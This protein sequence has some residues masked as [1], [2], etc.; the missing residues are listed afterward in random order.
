MINLIHWSEIFTKFLKTHVTFVLSHR[1]HTDI[2]IQIL[3]ILKYS[4]QNVSRIQDEN[5]DHA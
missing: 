1:Y 2:S 3:K 4:K 5:F